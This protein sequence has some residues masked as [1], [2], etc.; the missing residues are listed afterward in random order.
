M[1]RNTS[2]NEHQAEIAKVAKQKKTVSQPK[3]TCGSSDP[4]FFYIL[5]LRCEM[6]FVR[7]IKHCYVV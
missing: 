2:P 6:L 5:I 3:E 1:T 4:F 7:Q